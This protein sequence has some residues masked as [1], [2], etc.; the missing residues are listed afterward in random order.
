MGGWMPGAKTFGGA[1]ANN[2]GDRGGPVAG[3]ILHV[4]AGPD[5]SLWGRCNDNSSNMSTTFQVRL[6]GT[7]EQYLPL[8]LIQWCQMNGNRRFGS[9]EVPDF[10]E[11]PM[12]PAQVRSVAAI[13]KWASEVDGFPIQLNM[14]DINGFGLGWHGMGGAGWG[15][16]TG[17]P[18]ELR[19][20]QMPEIVAL[21][22]GNP[23]PTNTD[24]LDMA[25]EAQYEAVAQKVAAQNARWM[26]AELTGDGRWLNPATQGSAV[27]M[28]SLLANAAP[29]AKCVRFINSGAGNNESAVYMVV[30][31]YLMHLDLSTYTYLGNPPFKTL[32]T[33]SPFWNFPIFPGTQD[34]RGKATVDPFASEAALSAEIKSL[35]DK[36]D[37]LVTAV[38]AI[39]PKAAS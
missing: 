31:H 4:N 29:W 11:N 34:L 13:L 5:G 12:N 30:G 16:H 25:T 3:M 1:A 23:P 19:K 7:I 39:T 26:V 35:S 36:L 6:D 33:R 24:W 15:G 22:K 2:D 14:T 21:A 18:G 10:P 20:A 9:I 38:E 8:N 32:D 17:C 37:Q 27:T 28:R